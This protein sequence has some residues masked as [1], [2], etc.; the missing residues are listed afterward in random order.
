MSLIILFVIS[1][2]MYLAF[3]SLSMLETFGSLMQLLVFISYI[4]LNE[5]RDS[6]SA[7][8]FSCSLTVLFLQNLIISLWFSFPY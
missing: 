7:K 3:A 2:P 5:R 1:S 6:K 4:S 8:L